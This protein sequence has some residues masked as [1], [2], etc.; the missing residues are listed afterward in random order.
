MCLPSDQIN[1]TRSAQCDIANP[2]PARRYRLP[3]PGRIPWSA[4]IAGQPVG[5]RCLQSLLWYII[6]AITMTLELPARLGIRF[7]TTSQLLLRLEQIR[8]APGDFSG[9]LH[10]SGVDLQE[11][12]RKYM[13]W[14]LSCP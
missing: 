6:A 5:L 2:G 11:R 8:R 1:A 9:T 14:V 10:R 13:K 12:S 4:R 3:V 7:N